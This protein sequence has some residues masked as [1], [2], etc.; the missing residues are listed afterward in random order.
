MYHHTYLVTYAL[1]KSHLIPKVEKLATENSKSQARGPK[2]HGSMETLFTGRGL[3]G[4]RAACGVL[5][6]VAVGGPSRMGAM[7]RRRSGLQK[8]RGSAAREASLR[9]GGCRKAR[10]RGAGGSAG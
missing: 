7:S 10:I 2:Q 6:L 4:L 1:E 9:A 3:W 8:R 5:G